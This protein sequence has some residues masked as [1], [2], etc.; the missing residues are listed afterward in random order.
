MRKLKRRHGIFPR[1]HVC[2]ATG[3]EASDCL[4]HSPACT[5][6]PAHAHTFAT[7]ARG[8]AHELLHAGVGDDTS[9]DVLCRIFGGGTH[10]IM[11]SWGCCAHPCLPPPLGC[12]LL[13]ERAEAEAAA[14]TAA[15][16]AQAVADRAVV[17]KVAAEQAIAEEKIR[18]EAEKVA[19]V[20]AVRVAAED[21][22][23]DRAAADER[24]AAAER[25]AADERARLEAEKAA[26]ED[27]AQSATNAAAAE[28][29]ARLAAE[30]TAR[31]EQDRADEA[32][33]TAFAAQAE[34]EHAAAI[35]IQAAF[36]GM[37][38]RNAYNDLLEERESRQAMADLEQCVSKKLAQK[39][40]K[41]T[42]VQASAAATEER[43]TG[44]T[45]AEATAGRL[46]PSPTEP[47]TYMSCAPLCAC[48]HER[49][50]SLS[51]THHR[52]KGP[53]RSC[54][55]FY[56]LSSVWL[57]FLPSLFTLMSCGVDAEG[58]RKRCRRWCGPS[59]MRLCQNYR[60]LLCIERAIT[61]YRVLHQMPRIVRMLPIC[62]PSNNC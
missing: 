42:S 56:A 53:H 27:A 52:Q 50:G 51:Q 25:A 30:R 8:H 45:R 29:Q 4:T 22:A 21:A 58:K 37:L 49:L 14:L 19:A 36:R 31:A 59:S 2:R 17:D 24:V 3:I 5:R 44:D 38:G 41:R 40:Q 48:T 12:R 61:L 43:P 34:T 33:T 20:E 39:T 54:A 11:S 35:K 6:T 7:Q 1:L 28:R 10:R 23:K 60:N 62:A 16:A 57:N 32:A 46:S 15:K 55:L 9:Q 18:L 26:A 47:P 13:E